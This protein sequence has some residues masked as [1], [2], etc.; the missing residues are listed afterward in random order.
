MISFLNLRVKPAAGAKP[1]DEIAIWAEITDL[2]I[3]E[4]VIDAGLSSVN[5][6]MH[7]RAASVSVQIAFASDD[8]ASFVFAAETVV[9]A[10]AKSVLENGADG[11]DN[12]RSW[13]G[14]HWWKRKLREVFFA[15]LFPNLK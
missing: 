11:V 12:V 3:N 15:V 4:A 10:V 13:A 9:E 2:A 14:C 5:T 6:E 8:F 7:R 1:I